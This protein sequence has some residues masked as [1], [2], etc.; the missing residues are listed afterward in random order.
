MAPGMD[1]RTLRLLP[2]LAALALGACA[3]D[4]GAY[5]TLERRAAERVNGTAPVVSPDTAPAA[6]PAP[7]S[8][9]LIDRLDLALAQAR[10]ADARFRQQTP[11]TRDLVANARGAAVASEAWSVATVAVADLESARS[12][13]MTALADVDALYAAAR[14][15]GDDA[16]A[17]ESVRSQILEMVASQDAVLDSLKDSLA[18]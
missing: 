9:E 2:A 4:R 1:R 13:A 16:T 11:R 17:I 12:E 14:I 5:P 8:A 15:A 10:T 18:I 6:L 7:P 3:S